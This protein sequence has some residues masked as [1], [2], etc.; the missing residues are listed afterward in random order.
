MMRT[1]DLLI[2]TPLLNGRWLHNTAPK[3][4]RWVTCCINVAEGA[5]LGQNGFK[6]CSFRL[7]MHPHGVQT[8]KGGPK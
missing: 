3:Y 1:Y 4:V 8:R 2:R 6:M 5:Q 7:F